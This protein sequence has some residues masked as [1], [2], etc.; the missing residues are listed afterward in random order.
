MVS[1]KRHGDN[2]QPS[3]AD[4]VALAAEVETKFLDL[5]RYYMN[6]RGVNLIW[7]ESLEPDIIRWR[8]MRVRHRQGDM[9]HRPSELEAVKTVAQWTLDVNAELFGGTKKN[10]QWHH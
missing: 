3:M 9:R 1:A 2:L 10:H 7:P 4:D 6:L 5:S 8:T